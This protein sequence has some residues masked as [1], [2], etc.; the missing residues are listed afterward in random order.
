M[1]KDLEKALK[2]LYIYNAS[3]IGI[4]QGSMIA[5]HLVIDYL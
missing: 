4:S 2:K 3:N 1:A 5:Q